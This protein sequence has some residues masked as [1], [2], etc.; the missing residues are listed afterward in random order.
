MLKDYIVFDLEMTGLN[1]AKDTILEIGAVKVKNKKIESVFERMISS[2]T[3][4]PEAVTEI[5]GITTEMIRSGAAI[6]D[7]MREF[8]IYIE[9]LPLIGHNVI[10][11]YS[12]LLQWALNHKIKL[13]KEGVDTL[14]LART[15]R[16]ELESKALMALC[17]EYGIVR[18][19][20]HR[21]IDDA[22]AT[23]TLFEILEGDFAADNPKKFLPKQLQCSLKRQTPATARQ[24]V[25]LKKLLAFHGIARQIDFDRL[26]RSEASRLTDQIILQY[27]KLIDKP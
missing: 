22:K 23:Q 25:Y 2:D 26:S 19:R 16:P 14:K 18:D 6:D 11:D 17:R 15:L 4:I 8:L 20:E 10:F 1:P 7:T 24:M 5:T 9:D 27:G 13:S 12:F 3:K 21:A